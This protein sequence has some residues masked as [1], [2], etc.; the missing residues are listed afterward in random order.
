V[1]ARAKPEPFRPS[2]HGFA[3]TN[4]WPD[5]PA[6]RIGRLTVGNA[7]N[8]L[9]GGMVFAVLDYWWAGRQPPAE[10]PTGGAPLFK[11]LVR[12]LI[13]SWHLP[14]TGARYY[15]WMLRD[16]TDVA[17]RTRR[18]LVAIRAKLERDEP[19]P[20]G[21]VTTKSADPRHLARN[22]QVLAYAIEGQTIQVYDPNHGQQDDVT[23]AVTPDGLRHNVAIGYPIRGF[24][25]VAYQARNP[26]L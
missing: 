7:G 24:F 12:R 25:R 20:L 13:A 8:G 17:A 3:F 18:E 19:V 26:P 1:P 21:L 2:A 9:C 10:Q 23:I 14:V 6:L 4:A 22:H 5:Q 16:D 15:R 11:F